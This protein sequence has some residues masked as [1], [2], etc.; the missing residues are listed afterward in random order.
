M[1]SVGTDG[2]LFYADPSIIHIG[3]FRVGTTVLYRFKLT[4]ESGVQQKYVVH[5]PTTPYF[6]LQFKKKP[7]LPQGLSQTI[8]LAFSPTEY[9]YYYDII[10]IK[11][12]Y[13]NI[14]IPVH[15]YPKKNEVDIPKRIDFGLVGINQPITRRITLSCSVPVDFQFKIT[16]KTNLPPC[17]EVFPSEGVIP[18]DGQVDITFRYT[19]K[20]YRTTRSVLVFKTSEFDSPMNF[21]ELVGSSQPGIVSDALLDDME[22]MVIKTKD[23]ELSDLLDQYRVNVDT[24]L[25]DGEV[26]L[27][28]AAV[29]ARTQ[30]KLKKLLGLPTP[31]T[32]SSRDIVSEAQ[33]IKRQFAKKAE[34]TLPSLTPQ[35]KMLQNKQ[36]EMKNKEKMMTQG[37]IQKFLL[38]KD[39]STDDGYSI[40]RSGEIQ[41]QIKDF[42]ARFDQVQKYQK[43]VFFNP[44]ICTG[45]TEFDEG[46]T[47]KNKDMVRKSLEEE[48]FLFR[49]RKRSSR[50]KHSKRVLFDEINAMEHCGPT[51]YQDYGLGTKFK[52]LEPDF[53]LSFSVD[54]PKRQMLVRKLRN[55]INTVIIRNRADSRIAKLR[56]LKKKLKS[57]EVAHDS[58]IEGALC[59][60][61]NQM[62]DMQ[63]QKRK[64]QKHV[65]LPGQ[66]PNFK[67]SLLFTLPKTFVPG[68]VVID[69]DITKHQV[70]DSTHHSALNKIHGLVSHDMLTISGYDSFTLPKS[71]ISLRDAGLVPKATNRA[72]EPA[73]FK[74]KST[75]LDLNKKARS[76][77][78]VCNFDSPHI[79]SSA[80]WAK[81][82]RPTP[83]IQP[84]REPDLSSVLDIKSSYHTNLSIPSLYKMIERDSTAKVMNVMEHYLRD[85]V[86][87]YSSNVDNRDVFVAV[88][89]R[90]DQGRKLP[91][92]EHVT[93]DVENM[94]TMFTAEDKLKTVVDQMTNEKSERLSTLLEPIAVPSET[95][96]SDTLPCSTRDIA[97]NTFEL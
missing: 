7:I 95:V 27:D 77:D 35:L 18:G 62:D 20:G 69:D 19:P 43:G 96:V 83:A 46:M 64:E 51:M 12:Q 6:D 52:E 13:G 84:M 1:T 48:E 9:R 93:L 88:P 36:L 22:R 74:I 38:Q 8:T 23:E 17:F 30:R 75:E 53:R 15:A 66:H 45:Q 70:T 91:I 71:F 14:H 72:H 42:F 31:N 82:V 58:E 29:I 60:D 92:F 10:R 80:T 4:N 25:Q 3:G 50:I 40:S 47:K 39:E 41:A 56:I 37:G 90:D 2:A 85:D 33:N 87:C 65:L 68:N 34:K 81:R 32:V 55:A 89:S 79:V 63:K 59:Y 57:E 97:F 86:P 44:W 21:I 67:N 61:I 78:T 24:A 11:T 76:F 5:S 54:F 28:E 16:P 73:T 49:N 94:K 26:T